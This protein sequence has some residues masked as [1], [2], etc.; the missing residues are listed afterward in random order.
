MGRGGVKVSERIKAQVG[1]ASEDG[2]VSEGTPGR[3]ALRGP[4]C[5]S[6]RRKDTTEAREANSEGVPA[7][8]RTV[9]E[10]RRQ[11]LR[12]CEGPLVGPRA[13]PWRA[14]AVRAPWWGR[15]STWWWAGGRSGRPVVRLG[16]SLCYVADSTPACNTTATR[17]P[18]GTW[19]ERSEL[20]RAREGFSGC[21]GQARRQM[22]PGRGGPGGEAPGGA[23]GNAGDPGGLYER[24]ASI[25][26]RG[27]ATR[28]SLAP[29]APPRGES[30]G[31]SISAPGPGPS[32]AGTARR[33]R[34]ATG[35][36]GRVTSRSSPSTIRACASRWIEARAVTR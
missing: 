10:G 29:G 19:C 15:A 20:E 36:Q 11:A 1:P 27:P 26:L 9:G 28:L 12:P 7:P 34:R 21:T 33:S 32:T 6:L 25:A 18:G 14:V 22:V 2:G 30:E 23:S 3:R 24:R 16:E 31:G 35:V 8:P 13:R 17:G 4:K 5:L